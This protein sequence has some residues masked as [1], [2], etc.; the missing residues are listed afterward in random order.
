MKSSLAS[1]PNTFT[2]IKYEDKS[3]GVATSG[4]RGRSF[5]LGIADSVT[6]LANNAAMADAAATMIANSVDLKDHHLIKKKYAQDLNDSSDLFGQM[7]TTEVGKLSQKDI[8]K[9]INNGHI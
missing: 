5:S 3:R 2:E 6:V 7:V 4:W 9:A 8:I 1:M